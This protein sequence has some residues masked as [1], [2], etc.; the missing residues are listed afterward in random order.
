MTDILDI[1]FDEGY[2]NEKHEAIGT[3]I[4]NQMIERNNR[5]SPNPSEIKDINISSRGRHTYV[6]VT[7]GSEGDEG[8][9][10]SVIGRDHRHFSIGPQGGLTLLNA[11]NK[12]K[13]KG[14]FHV[15]H[16]LTR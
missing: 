11:K 1:Q 2:A 10:L 5:T 15:V 12:R 14:R 6:S 7:I 9:M 16:A 3:S 13:N 8:T 4:I